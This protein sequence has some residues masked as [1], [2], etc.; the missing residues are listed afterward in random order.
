MQKN[1][2]GLSLVELSISILVIGI[3]LAGVIEGSSLIRS[4]KIR[5][6]VT[7]FT[8]YNSLVNSFEQQYH[9]LPGDIPNAQ[10]YWPAASVGNGNGII[11][12]DNSNHYSENLL[13][14]QHL[15]LSGLLAGPY[16]GIPVDGSTDLGVGINIPVSDPYSQIGYLYTQSN[17]GNIS[18]YYYGNT[19]LALMATA[20]SGGQPLF[21]ALT[22]KDAYSIDM[23]I[24]DGIAASG[25]FITIRQPGSSGCL[26]ND[27]NAASANYIL[28]NTDADCI[29]LYWY[30]KI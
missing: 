6:I 3:I 18:F 5:K 30:R 21:G 29:M 2:A 1:N 9:Y 24:D 4:A 15:V 8:N 19:G 12:G 25:N 11:D 26:D 16:N 13:L 23:K 22:A 20:I 27:Y 10:Q 17:P 7:E 28:D 14:W